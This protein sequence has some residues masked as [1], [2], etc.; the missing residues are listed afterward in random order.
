VNR[1]LRLASAAW[2][3]TAPT[4]LEVFAAK[5]DAAVAEAKGGGADLLLLPE[6]AAMEL[7]A[8]YK[9]AGDVTRELAAICAAAPAILRLYREAAARHGIWLQPGTLPFRE[10]GI[11]T[12][13]AP[14]ISPGFGLAFQDKHVMTRFE[15]EQWGVTP[16]TPPA[17]FTTPWGRIGIA[18]CYDLEFP[19]LVRA[20]TEAGAWLILAPSCTDSI[21]GFNRVRLSARA[22]ALENQVFVAVSSTVGLAPGL[23]S[24]DENHGAGA[25]YGPV[26]RGFSADGIIVQGVLDEAGLVFADLDPARLDRV[27]AEGAVRNFRD[28][29][30]GPGICTVRDVEKH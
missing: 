17:V 29:P 18:I 19:N 14:L 4:S 3:I 22:R 27:R 20:Q 23:G 7:A 11:V 15:A 24:L 12:N 25:V 13:R 30:S 10:N 16:G 5:L 9:G 21:A 28:W 6:Y 8:G 26:D 2:P 1:P